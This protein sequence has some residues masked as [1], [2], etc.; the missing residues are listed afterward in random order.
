VS[1]PTPAAAVG[2]RGRAFAHELQ[3][4]AE[5]PQAL[6]RILEAAAAGQHGPS[7]IS[8]RAKASIG[9]KGGRFSLTD[10]AATEVGHTGGDCNADEP[11]AVWLAWANEV[12]A[13]VEQAIGEGKTTLQSL[14]SAIRIEIA[15]A[16]AEAELVEGLAAEGNDPLFRLRIR[17]WAVANGDFA[18]LAPV[19]AA[20]IRVIEFDYDVSEFLNVRTA[21]ELRE[22]PSSGRS[23][24]VAFARL[25]GHERDPLLIDGLTARILQLSDGTRTAA[26]ICGQLD[27]E[28]DVPSTSIDDN[29]KWME[30]MFVGGLIRLQDA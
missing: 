3:Q 29:L 24:L 28:A 6:E 1:D 5:F 23:Y 14:A 18:G 8:E 21:G 26:Q 13:A 20:G 2:A 25:A 22:M 12:L 27:Q 10:L 16:E 7:S 15:V 30:R 11:A 17:R 9:A 19:C 4:D